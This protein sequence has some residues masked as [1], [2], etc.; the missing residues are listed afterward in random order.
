MHTELELHQETTFLTDFSVEPFLC[1]CCSHTNTLKIQFIA[2]ILWALSAIRDEK[3]DKDFVI[4]SIILLELLLPLIDSQ[5]DGSI[6]RVT[7][8]TRQYIKDITFV[9]INCLLC[10]RT[11]S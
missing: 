4:E 2:F 10:S 5:W 7:T 6:L 9:Q 3:D 1:G 8:I 11:Q